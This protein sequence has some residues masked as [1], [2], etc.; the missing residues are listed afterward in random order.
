M[1]M[2]LVV[3]VVLVV[4]VVVVLLLLVTELQ[5][6]GIMVELV[7]QQL[8][9]LLRPVVAVV[10]HLQLVVMRPMLPLVRVEMAQ[11]HQSLALP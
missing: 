6:R 10:D 2:L 11:P 4:A 7:G 8:V 1:E 5:V 9:P 3:M